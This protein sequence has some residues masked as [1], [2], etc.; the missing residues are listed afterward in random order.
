LVREHRH[1]PV[2]KSVVEYRKISFDSFCALR[3]SHRLRGWLDRAVAEHAF[4]DPLAASL[5]CQQGKD[6]DPDII[7]D[8]DDE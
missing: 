8:Y 1:F 5:C 6:L 3:T 2:S 4:V 7:P